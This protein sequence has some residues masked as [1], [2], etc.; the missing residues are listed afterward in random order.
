MNIK[1]K[2]QEQSDV[3]SLAREAGGR[4]SSLRPASTENLRAF[5]CEFYKRLKRA[6]P[7]VLIELAMRGVGNKLITWS[8]NKV[9]TK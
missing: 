3:S 4:L 5:C 9:N 2:I 8:G 7:H 1:T 6:P